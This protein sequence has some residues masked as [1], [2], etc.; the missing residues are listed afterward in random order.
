MLLFIRWFVY[1]C[2]I[3]LFSLGIC[4]TI[5]V[6]HLGVQSWD[7]LHIGL[8]ET[9][10]LTIGSWSIIIGMCLVGIAFAINRSLV[11]L[12]TFLNI[13]FVGMFVDLFLWL[14]FL[15]KATHTWLDMITITVGILIMGVAGGMYNS[16]KVGA[17]PRDGFMLG[18]SMKWNISIGKVRMITES[19]IVVIGFFFG[20]PVFIFTILF[21]FVQSPIFQYSFMQFNKLIYALE[22]KYN[23]RRLLNLK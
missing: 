20:G 3:I 14:D 15:P 1:S 19:S 18:I 21:T 2:G 8:Y 22:V 11:Q 12:G 16:G 9:F 23:K 13:I 4:L 17:G 6:K 5:N 10:G 7:V